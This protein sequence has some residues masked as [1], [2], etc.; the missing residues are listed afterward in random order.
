MKLKKCRNCQGKKLTELFSLGKLS[1]TGK[2]PKNLNTNIVKSSF[3]HTPENEYNEVVYNL[4]KDHNKY[5]LS[6]GQQIATQMGMNKIPE[7][8]LLEY[9]FDNTA[10]NNLDDLFI[11]VKFKNDG[12][13]I[14]SSRVIIF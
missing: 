11:S 14:V 12:K 2:F 8:K 6:S 4:L 5:K 10:D 1:Y 13:K 3:T 9:D 7:K